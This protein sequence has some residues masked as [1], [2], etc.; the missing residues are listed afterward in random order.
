MRFLRTVRD[1]FATARSA[2]DRW[3]IARWAGIAVTAVAT[4]VAVLFASF[5]GVALVLT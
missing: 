1:A 5:V 4:T 2:F 3:Q